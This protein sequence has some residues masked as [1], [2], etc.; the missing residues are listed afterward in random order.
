LLD[1][2]VGNDVCTVLSMRD[3]GTYIDRTLPDRARTGI[4]DVVS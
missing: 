3:N 2:Y 1:F 4:L